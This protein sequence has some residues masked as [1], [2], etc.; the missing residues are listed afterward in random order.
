MGVFGD[1]GSGVAEEFADDFEP[2]AGVEEVAAEMRLS[3]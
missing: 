2:E 1:G 3:V